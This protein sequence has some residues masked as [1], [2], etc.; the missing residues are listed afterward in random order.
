MG[1]ESLGM[2][3][4]ELG[5][6]SWD[7]NAWVPPSEIVENIL[8][9]LQH[10]Q[11]LCNLDLPFVY[12]MDDLVEKRSLESEY[13]VFDCQHNILEP[14]RGLP[15]FKSDPHRV[16]SFYNTGHSRLTPKGQRMFLLKTASKTVPI[17]SKLNSAQLEPILVLPTVRSCS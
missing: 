16:I 15:G 3:D 5:G 11:Y 12:S 6:P 10:V 7:P 4:I 2:S 9:E 1:T 13:Q 8:T 17:E 14:I